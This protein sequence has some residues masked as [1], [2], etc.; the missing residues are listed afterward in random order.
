MTEPANVAALT[1]IAEILN[2]LDSDSDR[3]RVF[4]A[5]GMLFGLTPPFPMASPQPAVDE[6][7][8]VS[9]AAAWAS[10]VLDMLDPKQ[11]KQQALDSL[12]FGDDPDI[13]D[14]LFELIRQS[15]KQAA[16]M[17][18]AKALWPST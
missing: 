18:E 4:S 17:D 5:A 10:E 7:Q 2:G 3:S 11:L 6:D 12:G 9:T 14:R 8:L 1:D 15:W 16:G 13:T